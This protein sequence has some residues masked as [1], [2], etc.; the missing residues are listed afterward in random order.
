MKE[1]TS[2]RLTENGENNLGSVHCTLFHAYITNIRFYHYF[3][4]LSGTSTCHYQHKCMGV[5]I[6]YTT[7]PSKVWNMAL[8][9][10]L[11]KRLTCFP[12]YSLQH[13]CDPNWCNGI[14]LFT[15]SKTDTIIA[16]QPDIQCIWPHILS[17]QPT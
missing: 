14:Y 16:H 12:H 10:Y 6:S 17:N 15:D 3:S 13:K 11:V 8:A 7:D 9:N 5:F 2:D 1:T 4:F